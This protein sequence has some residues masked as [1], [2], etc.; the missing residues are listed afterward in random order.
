MIKRK[1]VYKK[2]K[3]KV[4]FYKYLGLKCQGR[5]EL[6]FLKEC[7]RYK[8]PI[9]TKAKRI[10][11]P[12]GYYTPD[13][14]YPDRYIEVKCLGTFKVCLGL[15][16]YKGLTKISDKQFKKIKWVA[17]HKKPLEFVI[18]VGRNEYRMSE[19][20]NLENIT[21]TWKGGRIRKKSDI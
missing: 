12:Y 14:E 1:R 5:K 20:F 13:F 2:R 17:K 6:R 10:L 11:T 7:V 9:P 3:T 19:V 15:I 8:R 21:I 4:K 16:A 18:Y